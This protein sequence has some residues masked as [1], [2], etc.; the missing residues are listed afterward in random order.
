M[1]AWTSEDIATLRQALARGIKRV[2]FVSGDVRREQEFQST[3]DMRALLKDMEA[4]L[5]ATSASSAPREAFA[6]HSRD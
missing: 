4:G 1:T 6:S 2:T 3:S 5:A